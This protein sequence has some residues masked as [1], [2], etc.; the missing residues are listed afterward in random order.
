MWDI[1]DHLDRGVCHLFRKGRD[2]I[3]HTKQ[4]TE[5]TANDESTQG[6]PRA[7]TNIVQQLTVTKQ[8]N[9]SLQYLSGTGQ[10]IRCNDSRRREPLP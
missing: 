5:T 10:Y 3:Q 7:D 2:A 1:T 8:A 9:E 6:T 4:E